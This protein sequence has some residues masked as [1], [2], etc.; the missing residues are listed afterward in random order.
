MGSISKGNLP[1]SY[2]LLCC[3]ENGGEKEITLGTSGELRDGA[4]IRLTI[5]PIRGVLDWSEVRYDE[6][7]TAVQ[8]HCTAAYSDCGAVQESN[9]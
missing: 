9:R 7:P 1:Y 4:F 3:D 5:M 8:N 6:L 2:I